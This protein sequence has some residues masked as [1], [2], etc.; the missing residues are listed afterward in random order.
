MAAAYNVDNIT[1]KTMI[2]FE[3]INK[4]YMNSFKKI[5]EY[6]RNDPQTKVDVMLMRMIMRAPIEGKRKAWDKVFEAV[7]TNIYRNKTSTMEE[8]VLLETILKESQKKIWI[9]GDEYRYIPIYKLI[10]NV[11]EEMLLDEL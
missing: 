11:L 5:E 1:V 2:A 9:Y 10:D 3:N 6:M 4:W 8:M 7:Y